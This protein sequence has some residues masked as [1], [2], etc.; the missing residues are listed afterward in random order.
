MTCAAGPDPRVPPGGAAADRQ[1]PKRTMEAGDSLL[2]VT[3]KP[4]GELGSLVEQRTSSDTSAGGIGA[5]QG[6]T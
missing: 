4:G 2:G 3:L 1:P 6:T 5:A